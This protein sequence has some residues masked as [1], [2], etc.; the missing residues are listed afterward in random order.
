MIGTRRFIPLLFALVLSLTALPA[1]AQVTPTTV[2]AQPDGPDW[3]TFDDAMEDAQQS[4]NLVLVDVYAPWCGYCRK[5]QKETYT[6]DTVKGHLNSYFE[7]ARLDGTNGDSLV[8]YQEQT[9]KPSM[10]AQHFGATGYPT[11]VF[12][13]PDGEILFQQPGYIAPDQFAL[14]IEYVGTR[15][16]EE[17]SF[18]EFV[19]SSSE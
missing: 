18:Q 19:D 12:L 14:M 16:F 4:Q 6:D 1:V 13:R 5:M 15:A 17:Q 11:T 3:L 2:G 9:L 7:V 8:T 10:L